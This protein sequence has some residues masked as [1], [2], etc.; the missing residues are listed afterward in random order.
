[1]QVGRLGPVRRQIALIK[2]VPTRRASV[3]VMGCIG[4]VRD[5]RGSRLAPVPV[6]RPPSRQR[7]NEL[8]LT[9]SLSAL[10][11]L[12]APTKRRML[13]NLNQKLSLPLKS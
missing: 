4:L 12:N 10:E 6:R 2:G 3:V 13:P 1:M 7:R 11:V 8:L 9:P 5:G